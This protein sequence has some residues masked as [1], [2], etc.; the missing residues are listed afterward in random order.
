MENFEKFAVICERVRNELTRTSGE[1]FNV[2]N[3]FKTLNIMGKNYF[4]WNIEI[5]KKSLKSIDFNIFLE[6]LLD[7]FFYSF[8]SFLLYAIVNKINKIQN[9]INL[10]K[11]L[12]SQSAEI[13][14]Q[15]SQAA[16]DYYITLIFSIVLFGIILIAAAGIIKGIIW[17][18]T[19][20]IKISFSYILKFFVM[21]SILMGA[22]FL[23]SLAVFFIMNP[24]AASNIIILL[25]IILVYAGINSSILFVKEQKIGIIKSIK[26]GLKL[27]INKIHLFILPYLIVFTGILIIIFLSNLIVPKM[28]PAK[29]YIFG[30]LIISYFCIA[31]YYLFELVD[32]ISIT[33]KN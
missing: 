2:F 23:L 17:V 33:F 20:K 13:I 28:Y 8:I 11:D 9:S 3:F 6:I 26:S 1:F 18:L 22:W 15:A 14:K 24:A 31:R 7:L 12:A 5:L 16:N 10:P 4:L 29:G 30:V 32:Y 19:A 27:S 25:T 21:N